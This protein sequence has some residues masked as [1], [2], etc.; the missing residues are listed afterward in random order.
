MLFA[1]AAAPAWAQQELAPTTDDGPLNIKPAPPKPDAEGVYRI[2]IGVKPPVLAHPVLAIPPAEAAGSDR[3]HVVLVNAVVGADGAAT[4]LQVIRSSGDSYDAAAIE[5]I[6]QSRFN[7]GT[8]DGTAVPVLVCLNVRFVNSA[9]PIPVVLQRY[10]GSPLPRATFAGQRGPGMTTPG[11]SGIE[12]APG[13]PSSQD[14]YKLRP[15]DKPP[16]A[17]FSPNAEFSDEARRMKYGGVVLISLIVTEE[18][19]PADIHVLRPLDHG[20]T[21][22]ALDAIWQYK[23]QPA[24]RDGVPIAARITVEVNFHLYDGHS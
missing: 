18:G 10:P 4:G 20:L 9:P 19:L 11:Q 12:P 23:F 7:P 21:E 15:G 8:V 13:N 6:K 17:I 24:L 16:I 5:A 3:P 22:K 14:P 2:G 1:L